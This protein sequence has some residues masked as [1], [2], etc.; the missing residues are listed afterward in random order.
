MRLKAKRAFHELPVIPDLVLII[1][2]KARTNLPAFIAREAMFF[3]VSITGSVTPPL[4]ISLPFE[5]FMISF[6][7]LAAIE[8]LLLVNN[9]SSGE[10]KKGTSKL[11]NVTNSAS[12]SYV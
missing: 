4:T 6:S 1:S 5:A 12:P 7:S 3:Q 8:P 10:E 11:K 9:L 2:L